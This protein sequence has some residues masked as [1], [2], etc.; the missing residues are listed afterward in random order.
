VIERPFQPPVQPQ[1]AQQP[2]QNPSVVGGGGSGPLSW[3][4]S[5]VDHTNNANQYINNYANQFPFP[6]MTAVT[7]QQQ[8]QTRLTE[9]QQQQQ[10]QQYR[11]KNPFAIT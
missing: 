7:Q 5:P 3:L 8:Q 11:T 9:Q 10:Q 1:Q 2:Q 6:G 4:K